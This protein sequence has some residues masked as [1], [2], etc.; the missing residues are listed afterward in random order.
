MSST[1][2]MI[3][4]RQ[5]QR[6]QMVIIRGSM[7]LITET[8]RGFE[9]VLE[10][11][12][13]AFPLTRP[14]LM[15]SVIASSLDFELLE[16]HMPFYQSALGD[17]LE[18]ELTFNDCSRVIQATGDA[19][20]S[21]HIGGISFEYDMVSLPELSRMI[22]NQYKGRP[23]ILYAIFRLFRK[24]TMDKSNTLWNIK[25]KRTRP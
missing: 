12:I 6:R 22:D 25:P 23:A 24:M 17:R 11:E 3:S 4:G 20:A 10:T 1:V 19:D 14:S 16:S 8:R 5:P 2:I 7:P 9:S 13:Q 21:Y 18:Y 15:P